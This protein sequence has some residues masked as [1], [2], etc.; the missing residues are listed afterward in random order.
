MY[1]LFARVAKGLDPIAD[2]F[3]E[4]VE[5]APLRAVL[6]LTIDFMVCERM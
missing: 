1:R 4:H 2:M 5:G 6:V 3:K